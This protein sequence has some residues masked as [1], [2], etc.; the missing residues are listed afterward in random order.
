[1]TAL[2]I[3]MGI[4][5]VIILILLVAVIR[6]A[7]VQG[8]TA[9]Y[10]YSTDSERIDR[11]TAK[12][13]TMIQHETVS[14]PGAEINPK[15]TE[16]HSV[17]REL[18]PKVFETCEYHDID[19]C[20]VMKW[21]GV[22][23]K[24]DPIVLMS[25]I[26]VVPAEGEWRFPPFSGTV[27]EGKIW[28]RGSGDTKCSVMAFYSAAEEMI[29]EGY[30]PACDVYLVSGCTEEIGG[31]GG[32][33][34]RRF[35]KDNGV[36]LYMLCDEGGGIISDPIGGVKGAFAAVG[37]FEK[38]Y[39]DVKFIA[40][41]KGG[42]ASAPGRN[43]PIPRLAKFI[44]AVEKK[45]PFKAE[46]TPAVDGMFRTLAPYCSSFGLKLVMTNLNLFKPLLK[47]VMPAISA[48]AA[49]MLQTTIGFTMQSGSDGYNVLPQEASVCANMRFIPHQKADESIKLISDMAARYD[50]ETQV[51][52]KNDPS[53][54]LDLDGRQYGIATTAIK[55]VFPSIGVMPY[56]VTG[57]TD[58]RFYGEICDACVRFSPIV[59][60]PEQMAGMHGL[61]ENIEIAVLPGAVDY[62]KEIIRQQET[63]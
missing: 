19:G 12:L 23:S 58:A 49:A 27:A 9:E 57:A 22:N 60:G 17:M 21:K 11:Y 32:P 8:K 2:Y 51:I 37:I 44:A 14:K 33:K 1:M 40:R 15:F 10:N 52:R 39:G 4:L 42:H 41:S 59:Y 55:K 7:A 29:A 16:F 34:I 54:S 31:Q 25:H 18:F 53:E 46:F 36:H 5:A 63:R 3:V 61:N 20:L 43:T 62:Y 38:G 56:V 30:K 26:D 28:G 24:L 13:A 47:K 45:S 50:I 35:F 6:T 48:Q